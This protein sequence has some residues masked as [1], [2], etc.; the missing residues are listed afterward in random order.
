MKVN[1]GQYDGRVVRL[2]SQTCSIGAS[3]SCTLRLVSSAFRP[4]HCMIVRGRRGTVV[5]RWD[6]QTR[7]NGQEFSDEWLRAGDRLDL[8]DLE[9][10]VISDRLPQTDV[11]PATE[12]L[13]A[14]G[15]E[16]QTGAN[17]YHSAEESGQSDAESAVTG[18][19]DDTQ[20]SSS[21]ET[22]ATD[23]SDDSPNPEEVPLASTSGASVFLRSPLE[24]VQFEADRR[25]TRQKYRAR[26]TRIGAQ[27]RQSQ[28]RAAELAQLTEQQETRIQELTEQVELLE[29]GW[30]AK[31]DGAQQENRELM[32]QQELLETELQHL[33]ADHT[34]VLSELSKLEAERARLA[35]ELDS[36]RNEWT[37]LSQ[38]NQQMK[39]RFAQ[40]Q[41]ELEG[42]LSE[43]EQKQV[44]LV[45][46]RDEQLMRAD[47]SAQLQDETERLRHENASL[48]DEISA[49]QQRCTEL[50]QK[51]ASAKVSA[52]VQTPA[53]FEESLVPRSSMECDGPAKEP[54]S[55]FNP[56]PQPMSN[57]LEGAS[58]P[59]FDSA[60]EPY[61]DEPCAA[62]SCAA[63]PYAAEPYAEQ[64]ADAEEIAPASAGVQGVI[65]S[66]RQ[67][68]EA[69]NRD[70]A[71]GLSALGTPP[72]SGEAEPSP[73]QA[74]TDSTN[75]SSGPE[76]PSLSEPQPETGL[77][78]EIC[79]S[80]IPT[81][82]EEVTF[83]ELDPAAPTDT[84]SI[85]AR[86]APN[87][88]R[89][90]MDQ[91]V[92]THG[93]QP[94]ESAIGDTPE[95]VLGPPRQSAPALS[96]LAGKS[97]E[98][99][100]DSIHEYMSALM[101]RMGAS[102]DYEP[103]A[104]ST[105]ESPPVETSES[106]ADPAEATGVP[107]SPL[108][109]DEM[110]P[111]AKRPKINLAA[112]RD[113]ANQTA[114][115]DISRHQYRMSLQEAVVNWC[116]ASSGFIIAGGLIYW[117]NKLW[118]F[119]AAEAMLAMGCGI[120]WTVKGFVCYSLY[121]RQADTEKAGGASESDQSE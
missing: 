13:I 37:E 7:L 79:A 94:S 5:R 40:T 23:E 107:L 49:I 24:A 47:A 46:E 82:E 20:A 69:G 35:E 64:P 91:P 99:N 56:V 26:V 21:V 120:Y 1:G 110:I 104:L 100:D 70:V 39:E 63:E 73:S 3:P 71:E 58:T 83:G 44:Q 109:E 36:Q 121:L 85:L 106:P 96:E 2:Q 81:Q 43:L 65:E 95:S 6:Q 60:K 11:G 61:A 93:H 74:A 52:P 42:K 57:S 62:E 33:Q 51:L 25:Q 90:V 12:S 98:E 105:P 48:E 102:P 9:L 53:S 10:E 88:Y 117:S 18:S 118:S 75:P 22:P 27:L 114:R 113:V 30:Q 92:E 55:D 119:K 41:S 103:L 66:E 101:Q 59:S 97:S 108:S 38:R 50:E 29:Q 84:A 116:I 80:E 8:G 34:R 4:V 68:T 76:L 111:R 15:P 77:S 19:V 14:S 78:A 115:H 32:S 86:Y 89:E 112:M 17:G 87:L 16:T 28:Q 54:V 31:T 45:A 67:V 72:V